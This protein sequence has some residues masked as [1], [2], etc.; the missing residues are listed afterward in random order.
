MMTDSRNRRPRP[1]S[2]LDAL[3]AA[4]APTVPGYRLEKLIGE[5]G[6]GQVW[7]ATADDSGAVVAIKILHLELVRSADALT[8]FERE[9]D[10]VQRLHHRNAVRAI[11]YGKLED[12]RPYL[13]LE[14]VDGPSLLNV[15]TERRTLPPLEV[16]AVLAPLCDALA[17][18]HAQGLIH[19]DVK[20]SNVILAHDAQGP[21]P[22]LLDFGLVKLTDQE[23]PGLTSSRT[24]LGTPAAMAP[25]Q[26]RGSAITPRTDIYALGLL[27][28]HMLT[29]QLAFGNAPGV[30][31]SY[32]QVHG[33][34][35]RPSAKAEVDPA[36]DAPI[37]KAL[38]PNP[39]ERFATVHELIAALRAVIVPPPAEA[40]AGP[41]PVIAVYVEGDP[42]A[43]AAV[44][45]IA[46]DAGMLI[47]LTTPTSLV[48]V[49]SKV[50]VAALRAQLAKVEHAKICIGP[51]TAE[52]TG[53][54]VDGEA[55][56]VEAW[57]PY[58]IAD[59]VWVAP[60]LS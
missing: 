52:I 12:G 14:Y 58:P 2:A 33:P 11:G 38:A 24:M 22:V 15:I 45:R 30:V 42:H 37:A 16:L 55:L 49:A 35:P 3:L 36:I 43:L 54:T 50:D 39:Q 19:R 4:S 51:T 6:F 60:A 56:D 10:A 26:L 5:G 8:R 1:S 34:R 47:A 9:I 28:F 41:V 31:Q 21:R 18:A 44:S 27:A 23:G 29:G 20:A 17:A 48:A 25:E 7:R 46:T 32:M 53:S 40:K 13:A 57:A 59:G